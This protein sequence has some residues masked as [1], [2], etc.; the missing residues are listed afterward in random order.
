MIG[1]CPETIFISQ[2]HDSPPIRPLSWG[3]GT[4]KVRKDGFDPL[5]VVE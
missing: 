1:H 2:L 3:N 5:G 4:L